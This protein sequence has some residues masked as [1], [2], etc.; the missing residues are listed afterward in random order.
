MRKKQYPTALKPSLEKLMLERARQL[1]MNNSE[2]IADCV[3]FRIESDIKNGFLL[4]TTR[5]EQ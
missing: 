3:K 2:F 4:T 5:A 1:E